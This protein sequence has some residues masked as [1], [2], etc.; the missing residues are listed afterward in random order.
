MNPFT[1]L[2]LALRILST[3]RPTSPADEPAPALTPTKRRGKAV[4]P[5]PAVPKVVRKNFTPLL[6]AVAVL[7]AIGAGYYL[8]Q[9]DGTAA[10]TMLSTI[11]LNGILALFGG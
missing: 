8:G 2:P 3:L 4:E 9:M 11:D 5:A 6:R 7:I 10:L 1:F